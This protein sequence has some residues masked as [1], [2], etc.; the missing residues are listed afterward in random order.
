LN[1]A[2][3]INF[4]QIANLKN[5]DRIK[6]K[7]AN[8]SKYISAYNNGNQGGTAISGSATDRRPVKVRDFGLLKSQLNQLTSNI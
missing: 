6:K 7:N 4:D 1:L 3:A 5:H 2:Q 8:G